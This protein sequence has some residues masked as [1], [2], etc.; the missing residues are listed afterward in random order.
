MDFEKNKKNIAIIAFFFLFGV[1]LINAVNLVNENRAENETLSNINNSQLAQGYEPL[2]NIEGLT[3]GEGSDIQTYLRTLFNWGIAIAVV[4]SILM[5]IYGGIKYMTT[6]AL[7][8]KTDGKTIIQNAITGLLLAL[9]A[10]LILFTIDPRILQNN[11][12]LN[13]NLDPFSGGSGSETSGE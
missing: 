7:S 11:Q 13:P 3:D 1:L 12:L 10:W 8:G 2:T 5:T 6:D 9:S 4:S